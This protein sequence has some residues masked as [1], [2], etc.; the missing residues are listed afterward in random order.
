MRLSENLIAAGKLILAAATGSVAGVL[1]VILWL[2][3]QEET[4]LHPADNYGPQG[5]WYHLVFND[6]VDFKGS[7]GRDMILVLGGLS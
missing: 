2:T 7:T 4:T 1:T 3:M 5:T 6:Q